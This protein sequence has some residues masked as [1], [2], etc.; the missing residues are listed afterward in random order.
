VW[1]QF[2]RDLRCHNGDYHIQVGDLFD[3]FDVGNEV[4]LR[5][6]RIYRAVAADL[7]GCKFIVLRGNHD[8]SRSDTRV[9]SFDIFKELV[10]GIGN[11]W[12]AHLP[13][14]CHHFGLL[15]WSPFKSAEELAKELLEDMARREKSSLS[16][17]VCHCDLKGFGSDFN[18]LPVDTLKQITD[19]IVTGHDHHKQDLKMQ[20]VMVHVTGSMQPYTHGEDPGHKMYWTGTAAEMALLGDTSNLYLR[21]VLSPGE[22][23]PA[24]PNCLGFKTVQGESSEDEAP[25]LTLDFE[26]FDTTKIFQGVLKELEVSPRFFNQVLEKFTES[27]ND[28]NA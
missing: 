23:P 26:D 8:A 12:V 15:P 3:T 19:V 21:V 17:V 24:I 20:G 11:I 25:D 4:V 6:A 14:V 16:F 9:S 2:E 28:Q 13:T 1:A 22:E 27:L 5:A 10:N 18:V 7:R